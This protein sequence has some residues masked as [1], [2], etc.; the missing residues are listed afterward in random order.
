MSEVTVRAAIKTAI[1][2]V[3]NIGLVYDRPRFAKEWDTTLA[4]FKT[5]ISSDDII[6]A[7]TIKISGVGQ[8]GLNA[9]GSRATGLKRTYTYIIEGYLQFEDSTS[10]EITMTALALALMDALDQAN[11]FVSN[12]I[13]AQ[14]AQAKMD[15]GTVGGIFSHFVEITLTVSDST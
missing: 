13:L 14:P 11:L 6:R 1:E 12:V 15:T 10:S 7:W 5:T 4:L 9:T 8:D 3:S 2:G